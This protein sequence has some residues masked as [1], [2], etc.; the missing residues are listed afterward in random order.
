MAPHSMQDDW[1]PTVDDSKSNLLIDL[2]T[3]SLQASQRLVTLSDLLVKAASTG[4]GL[5]FY[6]L[7]QTQEVNVS[8]HQLLENATEKAKL[9]HG[10]NGVSP[11]S[12]FLI[13]FTS[14][15][16]NIE[17]LWAIILAGYLPA[18]STPFVNETNQ[19]KKHL[20]HLH[21]LLDNPVV[22][23]TSGLLNDFVEDH[24]LDV[25]TVESLRPSDSAADQRP[26]AEIKGDDTAILMLTSGSTGSCKA[27]PLT[28][29]Q[30]LTSLQGKSSHHGT[31]SATTFMNWIG[32]DHVANL[33]E[34]H[35]HAMSLCANQVQVQAA[36]LVHDPLRFLE[37][38]AK[39]N[40]EYTFAPNFFLSKL[41]EALDA[42][43]QFEAGLSTLKALISGG[44]SNVVS[45]CTALTHHLKRLGVQGEVIRPG[46]GM[47]ETCAGSIYSRD[48][49]SG[50]ASHGLDYANLGT[51]VPGIKMRVM[52]SADIEGKVEEMGDL[53]V[54]GPIVFR[55]YFNNPA[56]TKEAFTH[57]GW[58]IT[59]DL[60]YIDEAGNLH[61]TGRSKD[62][63]IVN[64][65]K[66]S[67]SEIETAIEEE[68]IPGVF[69]SYT[70]AFPHRPAGS[71]TE[72]VCVLYH[73]EESG[74]PQ[75]GYETHIAISKIVS[76]I[77]SKAP[78][79][80]IPLPKELLEKSSL[81]KISRTKVRA[82]FEKGDYST[83]EET[84]SHLLTE[85]R[86]SQWRAASTPTEHLVLST[87]STLMSIPA[88]SLNTRDSIFDYGLSSFNLIT[89]KRRKSI[90]PSRLC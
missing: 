41:R 86:T 70:V 83:F 80:L 65:V 10:I 66:Y 33:T 48:C 34:I 69:P 78:D 84:H 57:D 59:G 27:V 39:H 52:K 11:S 67:S 64:G 47:T 19:R 60:A 36:D 12:I 81:G 75:E 79:H 16:D 7:H 8:Y 50:D 20:A 6:P 51:C 31:S 58:F 18:I 1:E 30:L 35:L 17:W 15:L 26:I 4:A 56:A 88:E 21:K 24:A 14:H 87:I 74:D 2:K 49:P 37:L 46:F 89:L 71:P 29:T 25:V 55:E 76:M 9:L 85:W 72:Q 44:E 5:K 45:T 68:M 54:A 13:H 82:A 32:L 3:P 62:T 53:Q 63:I 73:A 61:L 38:V 28:H 43:P 23:T 40:I 42:S 90:F 77:T 22:L